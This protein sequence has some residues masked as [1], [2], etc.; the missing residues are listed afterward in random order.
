MRR[1][2]LGICTAAVLAAAG[3]AMGGCATEEY[4]DQSVAAH[5][6]QND[7]QFSDVNARVDQVK[8]DAQAA[9]A[10]ANEAHKLAEG[11]FQ[12]AVL[13]TDDSVKFDTASADLSADAKASL[14]AFADKIK[15][16]N[17]N[18]YIEVQGHADARGAASYNNKLA[19]ARA[20]A[21]VTFLNTQGIPLYHMNQISYGERKSTGKGDQED[22]RAVLI[23]MN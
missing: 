10:R 17:K 9:L 16:D 11:D 12:H 3:L 4:V 23:V 6:A 7:Q 15:S 8:A 19:Q 5:N 20:D 22:R 14:T 18:V 21:V 13:F 2:A 1:H